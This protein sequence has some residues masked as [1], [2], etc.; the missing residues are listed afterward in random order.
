MF[1]CEIV[2]LDE[3][4][5]HLLSNNVAVD[6]EMLSTPV[7]DWILEMCTAALLLQNNGMGL[8]IDTCRSIRR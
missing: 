4:V 5:E 3:F 1:C 6:I 7:K 8:F 2:C